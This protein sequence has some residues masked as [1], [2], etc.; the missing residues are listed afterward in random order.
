MLK[1]APMFKKVEV[2]AKGRVRPSPTCWFLI[3]PSLPLFSLCSRPRLLPLSLPPSARVGALGG[4]VVGGGGGGEEDVG[5]AVAG[6]VEGAADEEG[7]DSYI[8]ITSS[9]FGAGRINANSAELAVILS[10]SS[11]MK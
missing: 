9:G 7:D 10:E 11:G 2:A 3:P 8:T 6:R 4:A 5:L 1:N